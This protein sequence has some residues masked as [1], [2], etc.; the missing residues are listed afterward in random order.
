[1]V[2]N[3]R[4]V[5]ITV[6]VMLG[7]AAT[8]VYA[9]GRIYTNKSLDD[10][11]GY[12]DNSN[13]N[14]QVVDSEHQVLESRYSETIKQYNDSRKQTALLQNQLDRLNHDK[15][16][17]PKKKEQ[18]QMVEK[19]QLQVEYYNVCLSIKQLLLAQSELEVVNKQISVEQE[20]L[21]QGD[22]TQLAVDD[23][24]CRKKIVQDIIISLNQSIDE[25]K[26][27]L[28]S[29]LN[30]TTAV[31]FDPSF[32]IPSTVDG[33]DTYSLATLRKKCED[34]NIGLL[35]TNAYIGF[36]SSLVSSLRTCVGESDPSYGTAVSERSKLQA[37]ANVLKQ[38]I[39]TYVEQQY[40]IFKQGLISYSTTQ[41]RKGI[42]NRQLD[43]LKTKYDNGD[44][45][46]LQYLSDKFLVLKELN[47]GY[48]SIVD[49]INAKTM[50]N[51]IENGII[52]Q[53]K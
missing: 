22:S 50:I 3:K 17:Y 28:K 1:M 42:L 34:N 31:Q 53:N 15:T 7:I 37:D 11:K 9:A 43:V 48:N 27:A 49:K 23:L 47:N 4:F 19:Y 12:V 38:Q 6:L 51:L 5:S 24:N 52:I 33:S 36:H 29:R 39:D 30:E 45:S 26:N 35:Q 20:K 10:L 14:V 44:I 13:L 18:Q 46:E 21:N 8:G 40:N 41:E 16:W 25:G 2:K 32:S